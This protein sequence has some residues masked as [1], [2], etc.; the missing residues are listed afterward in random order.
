MLSVYLFYCYS[1][2]PGCFPGLAFHLLTLVLCSSQRYS[3]Q[4]QLTLPEYLISSPVFSGV[5]VT[6]S[7]VFCVV[8]C[9]SLFFILFFFLLAIV[10]SVCLR[11]TN[12]DYSF[13]ILKLSSYSDVQRILC[14]DFVL[15][16][17]V[18]STLCCQVFFLDCL[19]LIAPSIFSSVY[20]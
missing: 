10:L 6:R 3:W 9:R 5:R 14:C 13:G 4:E 16:F 8:Y 18:L 2:C 1:I 19:F 12:S 11:F 7:L 20:S 17:F 15:F